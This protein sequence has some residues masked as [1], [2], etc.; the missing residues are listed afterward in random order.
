MAGSRPARGKRLV[1]A[2]GPAP[3]RGEAGGADRTALNGQVDGAALDGLSGG[4]GEGGS[5]P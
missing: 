5:G 4:A 3:E 1:R 2:S